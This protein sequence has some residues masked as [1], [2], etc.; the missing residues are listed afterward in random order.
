MQRIA[1]IGSGYVG[2]V[3]AAC[4]A[5]LG[6]QIICVDNDKKK[7][8]SLKKG[9]IPIYE[10]GLEELI[11]KNRKA[12]RLVFVSSIKEA[13]QKS[14]I[15]FICVGT[16]SRT[17]GSADLSAVE[18]VAYSIARSMKEYKIIVEKSTVPAETGEKIKK[19]IK[20]SNPHK[21]SFDVVSNPEFLREGQAIN[22]AMHP[23]RI[24]L[25]L[26]SKT[27]EETMR[28]L[29]APLKAPMIVCNIETAEIIKHASN[30]F[31]AT[32]ISFVNA[33]ATICERVGADIEKVAEAMGLDKRIGRAFL[34]AGVGYGGSCFP[35]DVDAFIHLSHV[36]G[37]DFELLK[38]VRKINDDQKKLLFKKIEEA[39]WIIKDKTIGVLGLSFKPDTDDI[40]NSVAIDMVKILQH[41]GAK[42]RVY[43]PKAMPKAKEELIGVKFCK[44][45][46]ETARN[47]NCLLIMTEWDE[48]KK[49]DPVKIKRLLSQPIIIDGRNIFDSA[50][51]SGL[52]FIYKSIGRS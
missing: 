7:V 42:I 31:L 49:I 2:L 25:G 48:F 17:D 6:N 3:T 9:I 35:K 41:A 1:V 38:A 39:L 44:D 18:K 13:A 28:K 27:A 40:R 14:Q 47:S 45:A 22:D 11:I 8:E 37:Y 24:V 23:D 21:V 52:G 12:K 16:P 5:E 20:M 43:D 50:K 19:T 34:N 30:S 29:Y 26:E 10:P 33:V 51:M 4:L 32:K 46:Y 36:K 15:I